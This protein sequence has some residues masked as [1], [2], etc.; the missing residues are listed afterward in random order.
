LFYDVGSGSNRRVHA[1]AYLTATTAF[2]DGRLNLDELI[3]SNGFDNYDVSLWT[4]SPLSPD[5]NRVLNATFDA[6]SRILTLRPLTN[7][8]AEIR[9][10]YNGEYALSLSIDVVRPDYDVLRLNYTI[11]GN[12]AVTAHVYRDDAA[13]NLAQLA[14]NP[15]GSTLFTEGTNQT[16]IIPVTL[17]QGTT[18][19]TS[20]RFTVRYLMGSNISD[21]AFD[22]PRGN[23]YWYSEM[24]S[25]VTVS[26]AGVVSVRAASLDPSI[27]VFVH[28]VDYLGNKKITLDITVDGRPSLSDDAIWN[29]LVLD[30][31]INRGPSGTVVPGDATRGTL[32][33]FQFDA[34]T[35]LTPR[36]QQQVGAR[37]VSRR[38]KVFYVSSHPHLVHVND[39]GQLVPLHPTGENQVRITV[40][41]IDAVGGI[42]NSSSFNV[43]VNEGARLAV[44]P[45]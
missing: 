18:S 16:L 23:G 20:T 4:L 10:V 22:V 40:Y 26:Q 39:R 34:V 43:V 38:P 6:T 45:P 35:R 17:P 33:V 7:G 28:F 12:P 5:S 27:N 31:R 2:F 25:I 11:R 9:L 29:T 14:T 41:S 24:P 13:R 44:T 3:N 32:T 30:F 37:L 1:Y 15:E 21:T 8:R 36:V 19:S 42:T